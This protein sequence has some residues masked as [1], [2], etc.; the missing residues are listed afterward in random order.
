MIM[1][2]SRVP[3]RSVVAIQIVNACDQ[4]AQKNQ[5]NIVGGRLIANQDVAPSEPRNE[6]L[7]LQYSSSLVVA[8]KRLH[9]KSR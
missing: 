7:L 4:K 1:K 3:P 2:K 5:L 9:Q 8:A 6:T